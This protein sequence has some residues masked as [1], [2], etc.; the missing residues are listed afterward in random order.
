MGWCVPM[1]WSYGRMQANIRDINGSRRAAGAMALLLALL[2]E[3]ARVAEGSAA[4]KQPPHLFMFIVDDLGCEHHSHTPCTR[5]TVL[6]HDLVAT[7]V[8][9]VWRED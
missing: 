5:T 7:C 4:G 6:V 8:R 1:R 9:I 3:A 2:L